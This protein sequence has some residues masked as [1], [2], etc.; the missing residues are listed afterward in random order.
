MREWCAAFGIDFFAVPPILRAMSI[1]R[2]A[3]FT[4][5][6]LLTACG[7]TGRRVVVESGPPGVRPWQRPYTV[8]GERYVPLQTAEGYREEGLA[9]WYGAEEHGGPTSNGEV[10]DMYKPSAAHKTLP[11]GCY[12]RVTNKLNGRQVVV[13]VNDRG[14]FI[15]ERIVDLSFRSARELDIVDCGVAPVL[16]EV[17]SP[18]SGSVRPVA[19]PVAAGSSYTLQVASFADPEKARLLSERLRKDLTYAMV[20]E[21]KTGNGRFYRVH[22]GRFSSRV[23]AE[24]ARLSLVRN[25][26]PDAFIVA[27]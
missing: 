17:V 3:F 22:A 20:R 1:R 7:T 15:P 10:F 16:L 27:P 24:Q 25:G 26:Y 4:F 5:V 6:F 14:P 19:D 11:L 23:D 13:R 8:D 2:F 12:I 21:V 9:S 18:G